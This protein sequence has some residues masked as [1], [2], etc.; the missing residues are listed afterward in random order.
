[1]SFSKV[2]SLPLATWDKIFVEHIHNHVL[3]ILNE[4][5][6]CNIV[7]TGGNSIKKFYET[8]REKEDFQ[9][10][11]GINFYFGDER[12]VPLDHED[13]NYK[14][15]INTLF[16]YGVPRDCNLFEMNSLETPIV[17]AKSYSEIFPENIDLLLLSMGYD[18]HIAS[19][20]PKSKALQET[21]EKVIFC[22]TPK[23]MH[24]RLT[25]TPRVIMN[26]KNI[27]AF[28]IGDEKKK[29]FNLISKSSNS[30]LYPA[31]LL[32]HAEWIVAS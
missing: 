29:L 26:A 31:H 1:M 22:E 9:R 4:S 16:K 18:G 10:L 2:K 30:K 25:I 20:F 32:S 21:V 27:Y 17:S 12:C 3:S 11:R 24:N 23:G 19:L 7:L 8:W 13:S 28:A 14:M 6:E 5:S 15:V